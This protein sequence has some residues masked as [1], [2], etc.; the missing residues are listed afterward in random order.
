MRAPLSLFFGAQASFLFEL[1][2]CFHFFHGELHVL[3]EEV[4]LDL[5]R[6]QA[7]GAEKDAVVG[8]GDVFG[9]GLV[10]QHASSAYFRHLG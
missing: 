3:L 5:L 7:S 9:M 4:V 10:P 1:A 8:L 6:G 2:L